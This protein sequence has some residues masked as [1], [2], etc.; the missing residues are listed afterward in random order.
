MVKGI[1]AKRESLFVGNITKMEFSYDQVEGALKIKGD[2]VMTSLPLTTAVHVN[3]KRT[4]GP[5]NNHIPF[6][7]FCESAVHWA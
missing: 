5:K 1:H 3:T 4:S 6:C 2:A 7:A